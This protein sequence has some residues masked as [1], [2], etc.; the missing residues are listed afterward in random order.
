MGRPRNYAVIIKGWEPSF[1]NSVKV[2]IAY[3]VLAVPLGVSVSPA[4]GADAQRA[5]D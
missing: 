5:Q 3:S 1:Y 2:T 4:R